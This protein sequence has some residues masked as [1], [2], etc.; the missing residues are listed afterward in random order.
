MV[1]LS[2]DAM[3]GITVGK[4]K[5]VLRAW[6]ERQDNDDGEIIVLQEGP[7]DMSDMKEMQ[8]VIKRST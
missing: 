7:L 5:G 3:I 1:I 8:Y 4:L 6:R 2:D